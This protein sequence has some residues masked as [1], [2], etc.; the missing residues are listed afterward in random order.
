[1]DKLNI[2]YLTGLDTLQTHG[3]PIQKIE[4][5]GVELN[6]LHHGILDFS[7][8]FIIFAANDCLSLQSINKLYA[9]SMI[10]EEIKID[11]VHK[12]SMKNIKKRSNYF[13][14]SLNQ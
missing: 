4:W 14:N 5:K 8:R 2:K 11:K 6:T 7:A 3:F 1:M 13:L 9:I 10:S 12:V